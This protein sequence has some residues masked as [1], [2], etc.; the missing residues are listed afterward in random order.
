MKAVIMAGGEGSRLRP[1]TCDIPKPMA[2]L[3]GRP[4]LEYI[5]DLLNDHGIDMAAVTLR[6]LPHVIID[7]FK[8][9]KYRN[10]KLKFIVEDEPLGTAGSVKHAAADFGED[11]L[12]ISGDALCDIDL[13]E[14]FTFHKQSNSDAT[15][16]VTRVM[17]PR[18]YG[19]VSFDRDGVITGF[20]E[21][22]GW[23]QAHTNAANTG[24]YILSPSCLEL[25]P[26][27]KQFD[28][29][30]DLFPKMLSVGMKLSAFE[31]KDYWCDIG[32]IISYQTCQKDILLGRV[33]CKIPE[34]YNSEHGDYRI[35]EPVYIGSGVKIGNGSVIGPNTVVDDGV[36]IGTRA[37]VRE[38]VLLPGSYIGDSARL[39]GAVICSGASVKKGASVFENAVVGSKAKVG[40]FAEVSPASKIWPGK[41]VE[42]GTRLSGNLKYGSARADIFDDDG[43]TGE[44]GVEMTPEFC[45]RIGSA[46]GSLKCGERIGVGSVGG[47]AAKALKAAFIS[48][49]L[50]TGAHVWDFGQ[51]LESVM[52]FAVNYCGL[53]ISAYIS[54]GSVCSIKMLGSGGLPIGRQLERELEGYLNRG[55]FKRCTYSDYK[56]ITDM[57]GIKLI[58]QQTLYSMAPFGLSSMQARV[59]CLNKEGE[60]LFEDTLARL[61]C[62]TSKGMMLN[63]S[64]DGISLSIN[65]P[66]TGYIPADRVL[67]ICCLINFEEGKDVALPYSAP[68]VVEALAE[69]YGRKVY[70]YLSCPA[71]DSDK[72]ARCVSS[73]QMW[74]RDGIMMGIGILSYLKQNSVSLAELNEK[75][76]QFAMV[77]KNVEIKSSVS[78]AFK[79]LNQ[80]IKAD[81]EGVLLRRENG[82][83]LI[84]PTKR[85]EALKVYAEAVNTE[86]AEELFADIEKILV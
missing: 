52:A 85:G 84:T 49:A 83:L 44:A 34:N 1:L 68:R 22:P 54:G 70:R 75:I 55:E 21:K 41:K 77:V 12:V 74:L 8:N 7:H 35:I 3:C 4:I 64:P 81:G 2:R 26:D 36:T 5:L 59:G 50:S 39:T 73:S 63:L 9:E 31:T 61:G 62:D 69:K 15:L 45:A 25:I 18:E 71:D 86:I 16:V 40:S 58:Y 67:A 13:T 51:I 30:R 78:D 48:G 80:Q 28:F 37:Y 11:F 57:D 17:D 19:L 24:I 46:T 10:V 43:I 38:S 14:A 29:A 65:D 66:S 33:K 47:K 42:S 53:E 60:R 56:D 27:N 32:D 20:L 82:N 76:P 23:N 72:E 6:Y 79:K